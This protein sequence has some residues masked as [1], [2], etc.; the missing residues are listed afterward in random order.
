LYIFPIFIYVDVHTVY[1]Y[2]VMWNMGLQV[3]YPWCLPIVQTILTDDP[4]FQLQAITALKKGAYL[5]KYGRRGKPKFCPFR[6]SN[7]SFYYFYVSKSTFVKSLSLF[8]LRDGN[9]LG[10][11]TK[12]C[13][14]RLMGHLKSLFGLTIQSI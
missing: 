7:V 6:L 4:L 11:L 9:R 10:C 14:F 3:G 8:F 5:L 12:F 13:S 1:Y 2:S